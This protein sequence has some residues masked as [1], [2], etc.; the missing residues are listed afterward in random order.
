MVG[1]ATDTRQRHKRKK[2][3]K[4]KKTADIILPLEN[5]ATPCHDPAALCCAVRRCVALYVVR[6]CFTYKGS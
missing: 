5:P 3:N 6:L 2:K 4:Q 1:N